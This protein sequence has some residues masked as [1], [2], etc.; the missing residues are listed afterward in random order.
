MAG[1]VSTSFLLRSR[2]ALAATCAALLLRPAFAASRWT[3]HETARDNGHRLASVAAP[4]VAAAPSDAVITLDPARRFQEMIG[5]GG[6]LTESSAWVLAQLPPEARREVLRRYYDPRDGIGYTLARTHLNSCDFSLHMWAL[7]EVPGDYDLL[8]FSLAP[9]R[10]WLLPL[11]HDARA[12]AGAD[13]FKLLV[14]PWSPPA[15][16]KTNARMDDGGSLRNEYRP[17][18]ANYFVRF[19][20]AMQ[21]EERFPIW[22]FTVQ[23]EPEAHQTWE[24]CLYTAEQERDFIRDHLGPAL[25][26]SPFSSVKLIGWDHN[27]DHLEARAEALLGD[28]ATARYLWGLGLHWYASDDFAA[29][30]RVRERFP[31]KALLF[32]EGCWGVGP[33]MGSW[34][35][36]ENYALQMLG[37]FAHG[38]GGFI[39]WNIVLD[40]R[41]GPNHVGNFCDAPV[42]VDTTTKTVRYSPAFYYIAHFSRFVRPGAHRIALTSTAAPLRSIAFANPDGALVAVVINPGAAPAE[43]TLA[44]AGETLRCTIPPRAIQTYV[45]PRS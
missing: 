12:V 28:P 1:L 19:L 15:W 45:H 16:M 3:V 2:L 7:D 8:H 20:Q 24:S 11:L 10:R 5:F 34:E 23:N 41:G 29:A 33:G 44:A 26:R 17:A 36:G 31:D 22:A 43:F 4:P 27:R 14:S 6:A 13:R 18:W 40:Q 42:I 32:T 39:D 25:A 37:D 30:A 9:M 35:H 21:D 38:V